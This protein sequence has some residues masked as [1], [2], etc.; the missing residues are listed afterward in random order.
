MGVDP[1]GPDAHK[2][3]VRH[4]EEKLEAAYKGAIDHAKFECFVIPSFISDAPEPENLIPV[5]ATLES[6]E[7]FENVESFLNAREAGAFIGWLK[8]GSSFHNQKFSRKELARWQ[9]DNNINS[10]YRFDL[11]SSI[12]ATPTNKTDI[13]P[14]AE[15]PLSTRERNTLLTIIA[16]LCKEAEIDYTKAAKAAALIQGTAATLGVNIGE[17]TI[18]EHLKKIPDALERRMK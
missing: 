13:V 4:I 11:K 10:V 2:Y 1:S 17:T 14:Q 3:S 18:E 6:L 15:K 12:V 7:L 9:K 5:R 8:Y 16:V